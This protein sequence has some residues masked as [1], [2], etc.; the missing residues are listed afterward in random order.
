MM[1]KTEMAVEALRLAVQQA[2]V[3]VE[4]PAETVKRAEV[5]LAFFVSNSGYDIKKVA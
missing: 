2:S 3:N 1:N 5:Y 4:P